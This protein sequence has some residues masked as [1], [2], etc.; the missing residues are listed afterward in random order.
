MLDICGSEGH[1]LGMTFNAKKSQCLVIGPHCNMDL[2]TLS[3]NGTSLCWADKISYLGISILKGKKF[4]V[5]ISVT[6][7]KFF[8]ISE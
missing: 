3:I 8:C 6:R 2:I 1:Q 4:N 5:D 7:R